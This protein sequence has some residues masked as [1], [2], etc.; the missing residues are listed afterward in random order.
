MSGSGGVKGQRPL[1]TPPQ[2]EVRRPASSGF[3]GSGQL[4]QRQ[5]PQQA[6]GELG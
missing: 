4:P 6:R 3:P 5:R 1:E 2:G